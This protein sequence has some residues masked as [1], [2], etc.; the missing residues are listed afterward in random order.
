M[1]L[2]FVV[3]L[4]FLGVAFARG[5][6]YRYS[7]YNGFFGP[8]HINNFPSNWWQNFD[9]IPEEATRNFFLSWDYES[10]PFLLE[11][12]EKSRFSLR[13]D[14]KAPATGYSAVFMIPFGRE[15]DLVKG[16]RIDLRFAPVESSAASGIIQFLTVKSNKVNFL[17]LRRYEFSDSVWHREHFSRWY[18]STSTKVDTLYVYL[19]G[20]GVG[21]NVSKTY[22]LDNL[23]VW[24]DSANSWLPLNTL[25]E[26][27]G[28]EV[29]IISYEP[30]A[31][32]DTLEFE[33]VFLD[34]S[35]KITS[36]SNTSLWPVKFEWRLDGKMIGSTETAKVRFAER[37][38][39]Y[40]LVGIVSAPPALSRD[41]VIYNYFV[42]PGSV[43]IKSFSPLSLKDT[44]FVNTR[45]SFSFDSLTN[46]TGLTPAYRWEVNS[47]F[48]GNQNSVAV[49]FRT[50]GDYR[51]AGYVFAGASVD[52]VVWFYYVHPGR[53]KI[54]GFL[55]SVLK[56]TLL[57]MTEETFVISS[58]SNTTAY[59]VQYRFT[60]NGITVSSENFAK[61]VFDRAGDHFIVGYA[62]NITDR[63]SVVWYRKVDP[64]TIKITAHTPISLKETVVRNARIFFSV[65]YINTTARPTFLKWVFRGA[66]IS[67]KDSVTISFAELGNHKVGCFVYNEVAADSV[68]WEI[69]V[70]RGLVRV[71]K[72]SPPVLK[73]TLRVNSR[74]IFRIDSVVNT[75]LLPIKFRWTYNG[76]VLSESDSLSASFR[77]PGD[78]IIVGRVFNSENADSVVW[79]R[80]VTPPLTE[81]GDNKNGIPADFALYQNYPNPF[82]PKTVIS[83][84]L[85]LSTFVSLTIFNALGEEVAE[86]VKENL[87]AGRYR[88]EWDAGSLP[89][90][91]Y[92][93]RF[94][95]GNFT[96]TKKLVLLK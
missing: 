13:F 64:G 42:S 47:N 18:D 92:F 58:V 69:E 15:I 56:D 6:T 81:V 78:H 34:K 73:D 87:P 51:I 12:G 85:P 29:K 14:L 36:V 40:N 62:E 22:F 50:S 61:I 84:D 59:P 80:F 37:G 79:L 28:G 8:L 94:T 38:K 88:I 1:R 65:K 52:S 41:S 95:G 48:I 74:E 72:F 44:V 45:R 5:Q 17:E 75:T 3:G 27:V 11:S 67:N 9:P 96:A 26:Q 46:T 82:N 10:S 4:L 93:C 7:D 24:S 31:L 76:A 63:D 33:P 70:K 68:M 25:G 30:L 23:C 32:A 54:T 57:V 21:E 53:V 55:P 89:S 49:D 16:V 60:H 39:N 86:L 2:W 66:L 83:F 43:K 77:N 35:F 20:D 71:A 91:V 90:G 19:W